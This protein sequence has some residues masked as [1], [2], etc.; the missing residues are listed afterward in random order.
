MRRRG[1]PV[2]GAIMGLL[3]GLFFALALVFQGTLRLDSNLVAI[4]PIAGLLLGLL[5][6]IAA[7]LGRR[8]VAPASPPAETR[9]PG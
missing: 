2:M 7:P 5:L 8:P 6:G 9:P 1:R 4:L 3:F